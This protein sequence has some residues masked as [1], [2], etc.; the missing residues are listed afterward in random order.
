MW[1]HG[2]FAEGKTLDEA[3]VLT[4]LAEHSCRILALIQCFNKEKNNE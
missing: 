1:G 4:S 3:Y 2:M